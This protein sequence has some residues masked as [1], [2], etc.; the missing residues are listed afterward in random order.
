MPTSDGTANQ[1]LTTN[2]SGVVSFANIN[3]T[4][5]G[6]NTQIQYNDE[7]SFNGSSAFT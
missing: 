6:S 4:P 1:V 2:G 5:G 3:A 7:G